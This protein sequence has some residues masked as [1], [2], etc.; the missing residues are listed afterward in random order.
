MVFR[1]RA[2]IPVY[3]KYND[4]GHYVSIS[5]SDRS[6]ELDYLATVYNGLDTKDFKFYRT[7]ARLL[8]CILAA[9]ILIKAAGSY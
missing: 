8:A 3:K 2:I 1:R 4:I 5:N 6:P 9:S 7:A